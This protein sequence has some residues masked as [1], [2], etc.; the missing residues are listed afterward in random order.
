[1]KKI[2]RTNFNQLIN[3]CSTVHDVNFNSNNIYDESNDTIE[4]YTPD[5]DD[6]F[7][8]NVQIT[9]S[10]FVE[11]SAIDEIDQ[12][13]VVLTRFNYSNFQCLCSIILFRQ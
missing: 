13:V 5:N 8:E 4:N 10:D 11:T 9:N 2:S 6:E 7:N 3:D 1:M 12:F